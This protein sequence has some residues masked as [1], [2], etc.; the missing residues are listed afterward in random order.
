MGIQIV[1]AFLLLCSNFLFSQVTVTNR[2]LASLQLTDLKNCALIVRLK[3]NDNS[4]NAYRKAGRNDIAD[5]IVRD[6]AAQNQKIADAFR[7][8]YDFSKVYFVY[9]R[10]S[11]A[12]VDG[13][14]NFFLNDTL[15]VDSSITLNCKSYFFAE[16][17]SITA[18]LRS[19]EYHYSGVYQTEAST[20]TSGNSAIFISDT[21]FTQLKEPF[22]FY[23]TVYLDNYA[24]SVD[25]LNRALH[26]AYFNLVE[27]T[28]MKKKWK[29]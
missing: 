18:N 26:K 15:A 28:E 1:L 17:G 29:K 23:Q 2:S 22:P 14:Q 27:M 25:R 13:A 12:V 8:F 5:R 19:D 20:S 16:Y 21:S 3:T 4:V 24:K 9:A 7:Q 11:K 10:N 6:R